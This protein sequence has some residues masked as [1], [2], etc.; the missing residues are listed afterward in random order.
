MCPKC[1]KLIV[2]GPGGGANCQCHHSE[3]KPI[4]FSPEDLERLS[5]LREFDKN[6]CHLLSKLKKS[7]EAIEKLND[8]SYMKERREKLLKKDRPPFEQLYMNFALALA[9]R[10][11]CQRLKVGCVV[12]SED[13]SY[14][15]GIGYNGNAK[16]LPNEC[17]SKEP[18]K[19]GC[20]HSEHNA[21]LKV[22]VPSTT[23]KI[24]FVTHQPC[25]YCAK[26]IINKGGF[27]KVYYAHPYRLQDGIDILKQVGITVELYDI[28]K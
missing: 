24:A 19:C 22:N 13:Y 10:S 4:V 28:G 25:V 7:K 27:K 12:T 23:P 18:G 6:M 16:G 8:N 11:T 5:K 2:Y 14:V 17:D 20:I 3:P 26:C 9:E 1:G 15:Y 21:L